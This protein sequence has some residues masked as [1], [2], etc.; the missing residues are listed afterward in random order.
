MPDYQTI[1]WAQFQIELPIRSKLKHRSWMN[2]VTR[3][4][5]NNGLISDYR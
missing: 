4:F 1:Y 2:Q 5:L 3:N